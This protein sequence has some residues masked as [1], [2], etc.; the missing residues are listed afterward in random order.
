MEDFSFILGL[1]IFLGILCAA[2][3]SIMVVVVDLAMCF[4]GGT[5]EVIEG[6]IDLVRT[7]REERVAREKAREAEE[8][9]N[10]HR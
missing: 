4:V 9:Y 10:S 7:S 8:E 2:L 6:V 1:S 5:F 3:P